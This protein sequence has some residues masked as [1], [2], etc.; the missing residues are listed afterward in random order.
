[1]PVCERYGKKDGRW[2]GLPLGAA[3]AC[4]VYRQSML[5]EAGFEDLPNDTDGFLEACKALA[6][7]GN[8]PGMA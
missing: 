1:Y 4:I 2:I 8:N 5:Q 3:G 7:K 6:A